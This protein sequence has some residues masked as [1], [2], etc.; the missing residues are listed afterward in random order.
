MKIKPLIAMFLTGVFSVT[1]TGCNDPIEKAPDV[2]EPDNDNG[3]GT[4]DPIAGTWENKDE[5]GDGIPDANDDFP[6]DPNKVRYTV[7]NESEPNNNPSVATE[8]GENLPFKVKGRISDAAD[9]GDLYKFN[10]DEG[11]FISAR[12]VYESTAFKPKLYFSDDTGRAIN[13]SLVHANEL[14]KTAYVITIIPS[15][16]KYHLGVIDENSGGGDDFAYEVEVFED[17]DADGIDDSKEF[18]IGV[19]ANSQDTDKDQV[20]DF[21]EFY[22]GNGNGLDSDGDNLPNLIDLDS[23]G[24]GISDELEQAGNPDRDNSFG[25]LD[26]DSDNHGVFD[27]EESIMAEVCRWTQTMT[28]RQI[29][30]NAVIFNVS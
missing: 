6:F 5:D 11:M 23:D 2:V 20:P 4:T 3:Y 1:L 28:E 9:N 10:A 16:G 17:N 24:D 26:F 13:S 14:L 8:V 12:V 15:G 29:I 21:F 22:V 7:I 18:A 27:D 19:E 25:F 30:S